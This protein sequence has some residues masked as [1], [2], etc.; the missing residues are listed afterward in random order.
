MEF[1]HFYVNGFGWEN[2]A[3]TPEDFREVIFLYRCR[4]GADIFLG[5]NT[6]VKDA[7]LK[8]CDTSIVSVCPVCG[9][10]TQVNDV[11]PHC[12]QYC[13]EVGNGTPLPYSQGALTFD[14]I[15]NQNNDGL[16]NL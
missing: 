16:F 6:G 3:Y 10:A 2:T 5:K 1:T 9:K 12:S 8:G 11:D 15:F 4:D 14:R 13:A 7:Y